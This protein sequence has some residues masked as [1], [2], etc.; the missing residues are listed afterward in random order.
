LKLLEKTTPEAINKEAEEYGEE[1]Y[2]LLFRK[3]N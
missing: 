1:N 3:W 2:L